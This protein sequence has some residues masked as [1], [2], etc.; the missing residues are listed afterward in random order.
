MS[1]HSHDRLFL[2][3]ENARLKQ[4]VADRGWRSTPSGP[5]HGRPDNLGW[6]RRQVNPIAGYVSHATSRAT[7]SSSSS[8]VS[9]QVDLALLRHQRSGR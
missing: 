1:G 9:G 6:P 3:R 2:E 8:D 7:G 4:I 5:W